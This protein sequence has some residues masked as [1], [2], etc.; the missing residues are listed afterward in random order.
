M[1]R[2]KGGR[3]STW[4]VVAKKPEELRRKQAGRAN[5]VPGTGCHGPSRGTQEPLPDPAAGDPAVPGMSQVT[6]TWH[7]GWPAWHGQVTRGAPGQRS[8]RSPSPGEGGGQGG[9][10]ARCGPT[11]SWPQN[12][13]SGCSSS[14]ASAGESFSQLTA[15]NPCTPPVPSTRPEVTH[16]PRPGDSHPGPL[17]PFWDSSLRLVTAGTHPLLNARCIAFAHRKPA[18]ESFAQLRSLRAWGRKMGGRV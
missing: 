16:L 18:L 8:A 4:P 12:L 14:S 17:R 7:S 11:Q 6:L 15:A 13:L 5:T 3:G 1:S 9:R 2:E 10:G